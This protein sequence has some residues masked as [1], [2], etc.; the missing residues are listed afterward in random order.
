MQAL[1]LLAELKH[2]AG[3]LMRCIRG[4]PTAPARCET[5]AAGRHRSPCP[6]GVFRPARRLARG[7]RDRRRRWRTPVINLDP[8]VGADE[9]SQKAH[10]LLYNTL[11]RI[12]NQLR[13]VPELAESLEQPDPITYIATL[14]HG[15][16]FHNGRELTSDDVVYTFRSFLDPAFRGR[17]G[18]Y[19]SCW[20]RSMP[21]DRYTVEFTLKKPF[22]S[23][24]D[25]PGDG[26]RAGRVRRRERAHADRHGTVPA[27][28]VRAGR[29][30]RAR[31]RSTATSAAGRATPASC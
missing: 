10:Q 25:Q 14:R 6:H 19:R 16:L 24:P 22:G 26:H 30:P 23:F 8:R 5:E 18:A 27:D 17:S 7:R 28:V 4:D 20:R 11:V 9:A 3:E 12:D 29:S 1:T 21:L 2:E 31:R 15:V 13:V